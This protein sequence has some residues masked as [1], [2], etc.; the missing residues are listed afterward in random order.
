MVFAKEITKVA[1]SWYNLPFRNMPH[2][3]L[4]RQCYEDYGTFLSKGILDHSYFVAQR[5]PNILLALCLYSVDNVILI[6]PL[7]E[8]ALPNHHT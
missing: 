3:P 7:E 2:S 6:N 5:Y 1:P 4:C 8:S